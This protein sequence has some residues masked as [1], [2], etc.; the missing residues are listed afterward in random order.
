M[1]GDF[2]CCRGGWLTDPSPHP[3]WFRQHWRF[4]IFE[5]VEKY[6]LVLHGMRSLPANQFEI[7]FLPK[8]TGVQIGFIVHVKNGT[9]TTVYY[10]KTHQNGPTLGN[11]QSHAPPDVKEAFI[12]K[13]LHRIGMGPETHLIFPEAT[14]VT[15]TIPSRLCYQLF[16]LWPSRR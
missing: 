16:E 15:M 3:G 13:L 10:L 11:P 7:N 12:Y 1:Y 4:R 6:F 9:Q 5:R 8:K 2:Q 14:Q